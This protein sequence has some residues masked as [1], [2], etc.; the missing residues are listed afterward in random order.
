ME[1]PI[2]EFPDI[3][4][5]LLAAGASTRMGQQKALLPWGSATLI[6]YQ[7]NSL[8]KAGVS[9]IVVVLGYRAEKLR[10]LAESLPNTKAILN[11]RYRTGKSSSVRAGLRHIAR[12]AEI[13]ILSVDQPRS[14]HTIRTVIKAHF[15]TSSLITY[16]TYQGQGGH[17]IIFSTRL[18]TEM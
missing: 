15:Q 4:A 3:G 13:L 16:P 8:L 1:T 2:T 18:L 9:H 12:G 7:L 5:I 10:A 17:P 11:L 6:E 14:P